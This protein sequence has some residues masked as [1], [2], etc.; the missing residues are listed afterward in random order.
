MPVIQIGRRSTRFDKFNLLRMRGDAIRREIVFMALMYKLKITLERCIQLPHQEE[1][2][3]GDIVRTVS[4][5]MA[6]G[7]FTNK[8]ALNIV[9][10][11]D[12]HLDDVIGELIPPPLRHLK[13]FDEILEKFA[14]KEPTLR[15]I[16]T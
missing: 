16:S 10:K 12:L 1:A 11:A 8:T 4:K 15:C 2:V 5:K 6:N 14:T 9:R 13:P 7:L 3:F